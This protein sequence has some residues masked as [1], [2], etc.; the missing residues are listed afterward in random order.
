MNEKLQLV[1]QGLNES[2]SN[3][4]VYSTLA[5]TSY[6]LTV[7]VNLV[8]VVT[9]SLDKALHQPM[10]IFLCNLCCAGV[11]GASSFY[12]KLLHDLLSEEHLISYVGCLTQ[13][14][15]S[16]AYVFSQFT[17]LTVMAYDRYLAICQPLHYRTLMTFQKAV[18]LLLLTW[19]FSLLESL[20]G[21][22]L[23]SQLPL[24][25]RYI[26]GIICTNW[27][28]VK[29]SCSDTTANNLYGFLIVFLHTSQTGLILVSYGHLFRTATRSESDRRKF[30]QTCTPHLITLLVFC[31][32]LLLNPLY[33]RYGGPEGPLQSAMAVEFLVVPPIINPTVYGMKLRKI[34]AR[35]QVRFC[36]WLSDRLET[37][38]D[39]S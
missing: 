25:S 37:Q 24:C 36:F 32:S 39:R 26:N 35:I 3:R 31:T 34:R 13:M 15:V 23:T 29:L 11:C 27:E 8:L 7:W 30:A 14:V 16:Y 9:V 28:V 19:T 21:I 18:V 17:S 2:L 10:F 12:I 22:V 6:L 33:S 38:Q 20:V 4:Q 1:L 5:L